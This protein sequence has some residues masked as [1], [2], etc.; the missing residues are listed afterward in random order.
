MHE[1]T[2][3]MQICS[4]L[5]RELDDPSDAGETGPLTV[6][7]VRVRV[8]ALSG[9]VPEALDFAWPH[10]VAGSRLLGDASIVIDLVEVSVECAACSTTSTMPE[11]TRLRCPVCHSPDV[12]VNGGNELDIV[13]VDVHDRAGAAAEP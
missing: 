5:E 1:L 2:V 9:I 4:A 3:A 13:S 8:G 7:V 12:Q 10:A 11:L 6:D